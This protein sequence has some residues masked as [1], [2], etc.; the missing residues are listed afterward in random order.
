M[1]VVSWQRVYLYPLYQPMGPVGPC[2]PDSV[3]VVDGEVRGV[4]GL[5]TISAYALNL[6]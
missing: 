4:A 5:L 3:M 2:T 6:V 1:S